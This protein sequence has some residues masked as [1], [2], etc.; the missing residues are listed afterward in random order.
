[1]AGSHGATGG[2]LVSRESGEKLTIWAAAGVSLPWRASLSLQATHEAVAA[3]L[4]EQNPEANL[5]ETAP[6]ARLQ[7]AAVQQL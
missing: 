1:M 3:C 4:H 6:A 7:Q 5:H 2:F